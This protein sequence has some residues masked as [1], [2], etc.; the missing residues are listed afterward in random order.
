MTELPFL[1]LDALIAMWKVMI[2]YSEKHPEIEEQTKDLNKRTMFDL[3]F[4]HM[5]L[6]FPVYSDDLREEERWSKFKKVISLNIFL[7]IQR[8]ILC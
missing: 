2:A 8:R 1:V 7:Y 5:F 4:K 3:I 6:E